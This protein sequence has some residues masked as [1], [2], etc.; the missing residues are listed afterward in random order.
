LINDLAGDTIPTIVVGDF[1]ATPGSSTYNI[2]LGSGFTD[3]PAVLG[4]TGPTCCQAEDLNNSTSILK[5]RF[6]YIFGKN[7]ES[8]LS[9][10]LITDTP[11]EGIRPR[12]GSDHAGVI[13]TVAIEGEVVNPVVEPSSAGIIASAMFLSVLWYRARRKV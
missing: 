1:N 4:V 7:L 12:W 10:D 13:A 5:N 2:V 8:I 3:V 11:F 9:A 6:D